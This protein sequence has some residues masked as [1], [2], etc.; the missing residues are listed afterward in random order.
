MA[1]TDSRS[2]LGLRTVTADRVEAWTEGASDS[3]EQ[4]LWR[5]EASAELP[6]PYMHP[7]QTPGGHCLTDLEPP[8][9]PWHRGLWFAIKYLNG[10]NF[11]EEEGDYGSQRV[12]A[13]AADAA[14][15]HDNA[16]SCG[17]D[18]VRP[19]GTSVLSEQRLIATWPYDDDAYVLDWRTTLTA[20]DPV[21][22]DRT[23]YA[24]RAP[25]D[26]RNWPGGPPFTAWGGYGGLVLRTSPT[27]DGIRVLS[28]DGTSE[29][30]TGQRA[31]WC[32]LLGSCA[33]APVSVAILDH[34]DNVRHPTAWYGGSNGRLL[35]A[36]LLFWE[37]LVLEPGRPLLLR[38]RIFVAD[39]HVDA[40][41][42]REQAAE[43]ATA[44]EGAGR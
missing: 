30:P 32:A 20:T 5:L 34:P 4:L 12:T 25:R 18:W 38:Y 15:E 13:I 28:P 27:V 36:A 21:L 6:K 43:F 39:R 1:R 14:A 23:A 24:V 16:V 37:P 35:N 26:P 8:D 29:P 40:A 3:S 31:P 10:E 42:M 17:I 19:D 41:F 33:D 44:T 2:D 22:L 9:H 11:W 7:L